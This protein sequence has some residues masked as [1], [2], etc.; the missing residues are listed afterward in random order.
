V[1]NTYTNGQGTNFL[2]G[3][4]VV[5]LGNHLHRDGEAK[6]HT[7][8]IGG[9]LKFIINENTWDTRTSSDELTV[10]GAKEKRPG[11]DWGLIQGNKF[12]YQVW[13][14]PQN[15]VP[16]DGGYEVMRWIVVENNDHN[17]AYGVGANAHNSFGITAR[18][19]VIRNN[20]YR[21]TRYSIEFDRKDGV[22]GNSYNIE[23]Y[24]NTSHTTTIPSDTSIFV[25]YGTGS[26][27]V[28]RNNIFYHTSNDATCSSC[29]GCTESN[30]HCYTPNDTGT[31]EWPTGEVGGA[32][33]DDPEFSSITETD[34]EYMLPGWEDDIDDGYSSVVVPYDYKFT[35]SP[36]NTIDV[37]AREQ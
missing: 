16:G 24:N 1:D 17:G 12:S 37:G 6:R 27:N 28:V 2:A 9:A 14:E 30:N 11:S 15:E 21:N 26:T 32:Y 13:I 4:G 29:S 5:L 18:D 19:V 33:C 3:I 23:I 22:V 34:P 10:R 7:M 25:R 35:T 36:I 31:C 8:R 20:V